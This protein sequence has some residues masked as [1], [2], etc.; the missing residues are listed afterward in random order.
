MSRVAPVVL[1]EVEPTPRRG[2]TPKRKKAALERCAGCCGLCGVEFGN[3][4]SIQF[5][6][7]V[8]LELGGA[9]DAKN[10]WP[11]H[12]ACHREKTR[13]DIK[14]IAKARRIRKREAGLGPKKRGFSKP[15]GMRYDWALG[16]YVREG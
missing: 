15:A 3:A 14:A 7:I 10:I 8:P 12:E 9:D 11:L 2:M 13:S 4:D 5:D 1:F 6:H 16:R